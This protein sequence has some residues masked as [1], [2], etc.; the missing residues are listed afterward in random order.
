MKLLYSSMLALAVAVG[1]PSAPAKA[2]SDPFLGDVMIVGFTF[3]PRGWAKADGQLLPINLNQSLYSLLGTQFGGDGRTTFALPDLRGRY[4]VNEGQ[5]PGTSNYA[6]GQKSGTETVTMNQTQMAAHN[7]A[8][9]QLPTADVK[10]STAAPNSSSPSGKALATFPAGHPAGQN[11]YAT[12]QTTAAP[13]GANSVN[14]T[15][16][17][18]SV[19]RQGGNLPQDNMQPSLALTVCVALQG[20]FPPRN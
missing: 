6:I 18:V 5:A 1:A 10:A 2:D 8:I 17:S 12:D 7:H 14:L 15:I 20:V 19:G 3:C 4:I 9:V 13:M 11:I 16:N